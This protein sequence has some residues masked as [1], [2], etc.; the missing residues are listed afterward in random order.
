MSN[1]NAMSWNHRIIVTEAG[2]EKSYNI[3]EVH[4]DDRNHPKMW[5]ENPISPY[6]GSL[7]EIRED[8]DLMRCAFF[9][10]VLR[11]SHDGDRQVL[12]EDDMDH[13]SLDEYHRHEAL[14]RAA[15]FADQFEAYVASH[16]AIATD[17][18][19]RA[20]S[21]DIIDRLCGFYQ[22]IVKIRHAESL[23][24]AGD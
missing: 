4:Y 15:V 12:V 9:R 19:L 8:Y 7:Q 14:D 16:P 17:S 23:R 18:G 2:G 10:S 1:D 21:E 24:N 20:Q 3:H 22:E 6:G 5:T 13:P 11:V